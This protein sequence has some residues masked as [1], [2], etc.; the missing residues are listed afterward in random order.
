MDSVSVN[1]KRMVIPCFYRVTAFVTNAVTKA[2][3]LSVIRF[4]L[5]QTINCLAQTE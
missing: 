5:G 4:Y 3:L 2:I 1:G